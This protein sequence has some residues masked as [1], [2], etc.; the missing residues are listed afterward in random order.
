MTI[1]PFRRRT[2][3]FIPAVA[4]ACGAAAI[5]LAAQGQ[6][7][8]S[9]G[10]AG[11]GRQE[12]TFY[13]STNDGQPVPD[14][15]AAQVELK[16]DG[17]ARPIQSLHFVKIADAGAAPSAASELPPP[18]GTNP[19]EPSRSVMLSIDEESIRAGLE[20]PLREAIGQFIDQLAPQDRVG[21][22]TMPH[23]SINVDLTQSKN[24]V[25]DALANVTGRLPSNRDALSDCQHALDV[26]QTLN[27]Q[28]S[29]LG[30]GP[31][32]VIVISSILVAPSTTAVGQGAIGVGS[33]SRSSAGATQ[34]STCD[35]R[36]DAFEKVGASAAAAD[37]TVYVV[38]PETGVSQ[39]D[40]AGLQS[41]A[42]VVNSPMLA[43]GTGPTGG[44]MRVVHES[45]AYYTAEFDYDAAER[46]GRTHHL[47][48]K[49]TAPSVSVRGPAEVT[50]AKL[51]PKGAVAKV[52][53]K[54]IVKEARLYTDLPLRAT[55]YVSRDKGDQVKVLAVLQA[56]DPS[57][58]FSS[59]TIGLADSTG[60]MSTYTAKDSDLTSG[61]VAIPFSVAPGDYRVHAAA[62]DTNGRAGSADYP[63]KAKLVPVGPMM[64]GGLVLASASKPGGPVT[65]KME[66]TNEPE[67]FGQFELY[68]TSLSG[69]SIKFEVASTPD[70]PALQTHEVA[71]LC[72]QVSAGSACIAPTKD[73]DRF[74]VQGTIPA[75]DLKAGDYVVRAV[76]E[77]E[78][79]QPGKVMR[80]MRIVK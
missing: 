34:V 41:L 71:G 39:S 37:A 68:G 15:T 4:A 14:L 40:M 73:P 30:R 3:M 23:G 54:D 8:R 48:V 70:G 65:A 69:M 45:S 50:F 6:T 33:G 56:V 1:T 49:V 53:A 47:D 24:L 75:T 78:G 13:A 46:D 57:T 44:L 31:T 52:N 20:P 55:A 80:T 77:M 2:L 19:S 29:S 16:V 74:Q 22:V 12:I 28:L 35:Y 58:K 26:L 11:S 43:L 32:T 76:F 18:F 36:Q 51:D 79:A 59:A 9:L 38:Q 66:F 62:V 60:K 42:G 7:E 10:A 5:A 21:L 17:K 67:I 63:I 64:L 72:G 25:R 27:G 61:A